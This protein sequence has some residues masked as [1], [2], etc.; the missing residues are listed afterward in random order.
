MSKKVRVELNSAGVRG[1]LKSGE[2]M[3]VLESEANARAQ[4]AGAGYGVNTYVGRN[5]CNAEIR[6]ETAEARRDNLKN[7][8]LL[9][10]MS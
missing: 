4:Q 3:A 5:R 8:T 6:A 7:N 10:V 9:K 2:M 1:L